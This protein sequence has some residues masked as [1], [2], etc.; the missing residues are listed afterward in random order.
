MSKQI[1]IARLVRVLTML[2]CSKRKP[3]SKK[4]K[5]ININK[6]FLFRRF[7]IF[8]PSDCAPPKVPHS[9]RLTCLEQFLPFRTLIVHMW[10]FGQTTTRA[11]RGI[12]HRLMGFESKLLVYL[13][14]VDDG[15]S[16]RVLG[17][18]ILLIHNHHAKSQSCHFL[19][20]S[21]LQPS[22]YKVCLGS[23][24][25]NRAIWSRGMWRG[26]RII[27]ARFWRLGMMWGCLEGRRKST[28]TNAITWISIRAGL[29][30]NA[31]SELKLTSLYLGEGYLSC[32]KADQLWNCCR[33]PT[34]TQVPAYPRAQSPQA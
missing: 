4:Y 26:K 15:G 13:C 6:S 25:I 7:P 9:G 8:R 14:V 31:I 11:Q 21:Q 18:D 5:H 34:A 32:T 20:S 33:W 2:P 10:S 16:W 17:S 12:L 28:P 23:T 30:I 29:K 27:C 19:P 22:I 3:V 24:F 1:S